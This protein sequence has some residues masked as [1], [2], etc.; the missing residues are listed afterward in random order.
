M[1]GMPR[2]VGGQERPGQGWAGQ[3]GKA[4]RTAHGISSKWEKQAGAI[5]DKEDRPGTRVL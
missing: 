4:G 5:Q 2:R 3:G 1:Q